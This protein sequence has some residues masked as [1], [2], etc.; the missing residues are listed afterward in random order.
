MVSSLRIRPSSQNLVVSRG[1]YCHAAQLFRSTGY[2][3]KGQ[4]EDRECDSDNGVGGSSGR[5]ERTGFEREAGESNSSPQCKPAETTGWSAGNGRS[6]VGISRGRAGGSRTGRGPDTRTVPFVADITR[7]SS[8]DRREMELGRMVRQRSFYPSPPPVSFF[9]P[10]TYKR[11]FST[12]R[13]AS[14][15]SGVDSGKPGQSKDGAGRPLIVL[16]LES[17]A[18]DSCCAIV[19]SDRRIRSNVVIQ[20]H[21]MN[22]V[23][24]GIYPLQAQWLHSAN[25]VGFILA[26]GRL[27]SRHTPRSE[28]VQSIPES[29]GRQTDR[30]RF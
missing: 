16:A 6:T 21:E 14:G 28:L 25:I 1:A 17:S 5:N 7:P 19:D 30:P 2:E 13:F 18:D 3:R 22:A 15:S 9:A 26:R 24:G 27:D 23:Y 4:R 29:W 12:T 10:S 11:C 20:Q 8:F